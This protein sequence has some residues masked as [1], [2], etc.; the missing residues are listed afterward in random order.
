MRKRG[1]NPADV[2]EQTAAWRKQAAERDLVFNSDWANTQKQ[3][4]TAEQPP[5]PEQD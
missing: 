3:E 1:V 2:M 5:P 4:D